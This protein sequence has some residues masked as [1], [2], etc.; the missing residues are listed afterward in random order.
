MDICIVL[1]L[2]HCIG[3][4]QTWAEYDIVSFLRRVDG[5]SNDWKIMKEAI[6]CI[7]G[8][9]LKWLMRIDFPYT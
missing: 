4:W 1:Y 7:L 3:L 6:F 8:G 5:E 2:Y 9:K